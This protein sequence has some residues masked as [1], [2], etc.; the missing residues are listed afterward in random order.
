ML[1]DQNCRI[2]GA[3]FRDTDAWGLL[4]PIEP[5]AGI[6][7][8][9]VLHGDPEND[10]TYNPISKESLQNCGLDYLALGH[11]HKGSALQKAGK[12]HFGWP[13]CTMGRG[14]DECGKK[15]VW[16]VELDEQGCRQEFLPLPLPKFEIL[17]LDMEDLTVPPDAEGSI[18]CLIL[19]GEADGVDTD[20]VY[21]KL[22]DKFFH[23]EVR[24]ATT[25]KRDLWADCGTGTL[26]GIALSHLKQQ[27]DGAEESEKPVILQA[28]KVLLAALEGR[29]QP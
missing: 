13:G 11:I 19:T 9:G 29:E 17:K 2:W 16:Y 4:Q 8:G 6:W 25:P 5:I 14:F 21:G 12:T 22:A 15:G 27:Y 10:S 18:C 20:A 23:L 28:A 1:E 3:G 7:E 26:R 24:N